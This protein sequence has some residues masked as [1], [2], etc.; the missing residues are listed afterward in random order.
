MA[1]VDADFIHNTMISLFSLL[2]ISCIVSTCYRIRRQRLL[3]QE[4]R[5]MSKQH[6][7]PLQKVVQ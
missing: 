4:L 7:S 5:E 2:G 3:E 6:Q 1:G